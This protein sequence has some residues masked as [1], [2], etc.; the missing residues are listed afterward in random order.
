MNFALESSTFD[1][2]SLIFDSNVAAVSDVIALVPLDT[3][4]E[5]LDFL[6]CAFPSRMTLGGDGN[7]NP[8]APAVGA[9]SD[10]PGGAPSV[11]TESS[12]SA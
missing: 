6:V 9:V 1:A 8:F 5:L 12:S 7:T 10:V 2:N 3:E 4:V 11:D